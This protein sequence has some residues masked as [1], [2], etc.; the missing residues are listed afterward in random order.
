[1]QITINEK[2]YNVKFG[3]K[4]VRKMDEK[5]YVSDGGIKFGMALEKK[6][7]TLFA[8][9]VVTLAEVLYE[10]TC[11]ESKRPAKDEIDTFIDEHEDIEGLFE[12][13]LEELKN[14]NATQVAITRTEKML[15][16][17]KVI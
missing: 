1:M 5:Y 4:F 16:A 10:G 12:E 14:S 9:D 7:P 17:A 3:V 11:A 8:G 6:L 13:V 15:K 2:E